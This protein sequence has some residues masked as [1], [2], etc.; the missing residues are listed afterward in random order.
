MRRRGLLLFFVFLFCSASYSQEVVFKIAK[1]YFRSDPF[2]SEFSA[3]MKHLLN[4]PFITDKVMEKRTD[5]SLFYFGG[6]YTNNVFN[7]FFFK[8]KRM[9]VALS[10]V[11]VKLDSTLTDTIFV[12]E[13]FVYA[14]DNK[15][16]KDEI[17]KEYDKILKRYKNNFY[18][19]EFKQNPPGA[20]LQG[21]SHNFFDRYHA[22]SPFA[23]ALYGPTDKKEM[24]MILTLRMDTYDNMAMLAAPYI[25]DRPD[26]EDK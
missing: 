10:E 17:T 3:F 23:V 25:F 9:E 14:D 16:G 21:G 8:P 12:Y 26:A 20:K 5:T 7:P 11:Q 19:S 6:A 13:L 22:I 18:K 4:D 2:R 15:E 1:S 24:C